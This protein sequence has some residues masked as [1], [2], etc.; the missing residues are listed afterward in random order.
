MKEAAGRVPTRFRLIQRLRDYRRTAL[1]DLRY[2]G[3]HVLAW[4][5]LAKALSP[6]AEVSLQM[7]F[8][9][10]LAREIPDRPARI[11]CVVE[12]AGE[13][14]IRAIVLHRSPRP[15]PRDQARSSGDDG[16]DQALEERRL[17]AACEY[18]ADLMHAG[19]ECFVARV[20]GE[21]AHSNWIRFPMC[22]QTAHSQ[23]RLR[24]GE[25]Y[26]TEGVTSVQWRG[27]GLHEAVN[28]R[29]LQRAR[30]LGFERAYTITDLTKA[31]ARRGV[32]RI[33]WR[34]RGYYLI[35]T[36]RGASRSRKLC[37]KGDVEPI[38][39]TYLDSVAETWG[40]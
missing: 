34:L 7:L 26:T 25:V 14:D 11:D 2:Q 13:A 28:V 20:D 23:I 24:A 19:E 8:E 3:A 1:D 16:R 9:Y 33:G 31:G 36:V 35:V 32:K 12:Q 39:R 6:F 40:P 29:L 5:A 37:L 18:V 22:K 21:I 10:D 38:F 27:K 15:E 17:E 4:R 30:S